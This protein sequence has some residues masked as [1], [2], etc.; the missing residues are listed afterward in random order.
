MIRSLVILGVLAL[1]LTTAACGDPAQD[2]PSAEFCEIS[3]VLVNTSG[4]PVPGE[5]RLLWSKSRYESVHSETP[6]NLAGEF[7]LE[8]PFDQALRLWITAPDHQ[9]LEV[10]ILITDEVSAGSLRVVLPEVD[11]DGEPKTEWSTD[12]VFLAEMALIRRLANAESAEAMRT[13]YEISGPEFLAHLGNTDP[14]LESVDSLDL[15]VQHP[16]G[17]VSA[18]IRHPTALTF[19][20]IQGLA[21]GG[22]S[23]SL[24]GVSKFSPTKILETVPPDSPV[25]GFAS[26]SLLRTIAAEHD[27]R[28]AGAGADRRLNNRGRL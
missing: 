16:E 10:P 25:W 11:D 17:T 9:Q 28:G 24:N 2:S 23:V 20:M 12:L 5:V 8:V 7:Q 19:A 15:R 22:K 26:D 14:I 3:G 1:C 13:L 4:D 18:E 6:V 21:A 27:P